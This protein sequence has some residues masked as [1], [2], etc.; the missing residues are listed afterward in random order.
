M[1]SRWIIIDG[2]SLLHRDERLK[3]RSRP[4]LAGARQR[5]VR[6]LEESAGG[7]A[8]RITVVFDGRA[9]GAGEGYESPDVEVIF[10]PGHQTADT[11][12]E[13]MVADA[14]D[15]GAITVVTSD[16]AERHTVAASGAQ[17][18][19]CGDFLE[20]LERRRKDLSDTARR[21]RQRM[22]PRTLGESFPET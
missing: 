7:L 11:V 16:L 6:R 9:A 17:S 22:P 15:P 8:G 5:L 13:R 10:A 2:Y 20:L 21:S 18:M 14:D 1:N 12:I 3:P 19:A 4:D